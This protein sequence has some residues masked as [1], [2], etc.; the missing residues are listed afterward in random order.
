[1]QNFVLLTN[2][3]KSSD[4]FTGTTGTLIANIQGT[5]SDISNHTTTNLLEGTNLY[6]TDARAKA[7]ISVTESGSGDGSIAYNNSTGVITYT[8]PTATD[9][10]AH[11]TA[12]TG[13]GIDSGTISIGQ[14]VG[15]TDDVSF[16][17]VTASLTGTVSSIAN[18]DTADL[19]EGTNL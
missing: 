5:T 14:S 3:T 13:V 4:T 15:T 18:H 16:N 1:M 11:F 9:T 2:A 12:G 17:N 7:A 19:A 6:Y 10:R 8:G